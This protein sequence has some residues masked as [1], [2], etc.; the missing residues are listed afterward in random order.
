MKLLS[1]LLVVGLLL[2][3][4]IAPV[5]AQEQDIPGP[6]EGDP[7]IF[8]NLGTDISTL[9][10]ILSADGSSN[11]I[12]GRI[13]PNFI[14]I[15]PDSFALE[16]NVRAA[17]VTGWELAEDG[18]TYTFTL[19]DDWTWS[20]GTPITGE[21]YKYSF[22]AINT[23]STP[24][25][26]VL[27]DVADVQVPD[28]YTV[29][30]TLNEPSCSAINNIASIPM[31]P[32]HVYSERFATFE[33]MIDSPLN[34]P[35][36]NPE[37]TANRW[38]YSNFRPGEQVTLLADQNFPDPY[39]DE[40]L[41]EGQGYVVPEGWV[42]RNIA[43][44]TLIVESFING[45]ITIINSTPA[46]RKDEIRALAEEGQAQLWE[47]PAG[48]VRFIAVNEADPTNP[49]P[50][51][52]EDGN[53][54]DQGAHPI[55][56]DV[57][58]RQAL[59]HALDWEALNIGV[60]NGEGIQLASH[61][62]PTNWAYDE[63]IPF[64]EFDVEE[65]DRLLTEA[66]WVEGPDGVRVCEGCLYAEEGD[67]LEIE[68]ITNAGNVENEALGVLLLDQWG[69]VGVNLDLQVID[70]NI[71]VEELQAQTFDMVLIFWNFGAPADPQ[72]DIQVTFDPSNDLP[73]A[74]FNTTSY[75]NPRVNE[76]LEAAN[77]P[78]QTDNCDQDI[79]RDLY[80]EA[81]QILRDDVPWIWVSTSIVTT[82][83][84]GNVQNYDPKIGGAYW[85]EDGY[86]IMSEAR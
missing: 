48:T 4:M 25:S 27:D 79:R 28:P 15:N 54:I 2:A 58:V 50:G 81:Y 69:D 6:G 53:A 82:A 47:V 72:S 29:V 13:F 35:T 61:F 38:T 45:D 10:P 39:L 65:A 60:F 5:A 31:V 8:P 18:V 12:I 32:S 57:R 16:P 26:Y 40:V 44:Q 68:L 83:A 20:D 64:Y 85:N 86:V 3:L 59:M 73:G 74:G 43:D 1:K 17:V 84:Q 30:V 51:L 24:L 80:R 66:G 21:D 71:L 11:T 34:Q 75:N 49:Q 77:D 23:I 76:I 19:R 14:G 22:D 9:N 33:D 78:A 63:S 56:G 70:F 52:D 7:I 37:A 62:L 42:F 41:G 46:D 67:P 36:V 55:L